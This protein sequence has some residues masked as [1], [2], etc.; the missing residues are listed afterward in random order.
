MAADEL[1]ERFANL[2]EGGPAAGL[3]WNLLAFRGVEDDA[4]WSGFGFARDLFGRWRGE[5]VEG[6]GVV[7]YG[8]AAVDTK[9]VA[10]GFEIVVLFNRPDFGDGLEAGRGWRCDA[11]GE[12]WQ[13]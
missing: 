10:V 3:E 9:S 5:P 13:R 4:D 12:L 6:P 2:L 7:L 11:A 8:V 1:D